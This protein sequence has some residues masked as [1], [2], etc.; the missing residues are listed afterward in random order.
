[1]TKRPEWEVEGGR[2]PSLRHIATYMFCVQVVQENLNAI[3]NRAWVISN[4]SL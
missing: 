1:M 3:F 2:A 4:L